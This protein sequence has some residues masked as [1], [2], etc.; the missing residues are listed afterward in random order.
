MTPSE[1]DRLCAEA[2]RRVLQF[3]ERS[4]GQ[5]KHHTRAACEASRARLLG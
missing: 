4:A 1:L 5:H 2:L 3:I